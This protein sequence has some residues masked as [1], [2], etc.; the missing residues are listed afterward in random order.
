MTLFSCP[1]P[2]EQIIFNLFSIISCNTRPVL[3]LYGCG[4]NLTRE[5]ANIGHSRAQRGRIIGGGLDISRISY[6]IGKRDNLTAKLSFKLKNE[7][8]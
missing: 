3:Y 7:A 1:L 4:M 5:A 6:K 8:I 2:V